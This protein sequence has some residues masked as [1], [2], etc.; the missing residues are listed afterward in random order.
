[1]GEETPK[2]TY[3]I[4]DLKLEGVVLGQEVRIQVHNKTQ[5][6]GD[7]VMVRR[8]GKLMEVECSSTTGVVKAGNVAGA[9]SA[10]I[11]CDVCYKRYT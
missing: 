9:I 7:S 2:I 11:E 8:K 1:M 10:Y 5:V 4:A 3:R 6:D